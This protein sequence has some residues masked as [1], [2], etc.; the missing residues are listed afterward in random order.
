MRKINAGY[1]SGLRGKLRA[2]SDCTASARSI[3]LCGPTTPPAHP[4]GV[5]ERPKWRDHGLDSLG[6]LKQSRLISRNNSRA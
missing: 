3:E 5:A 4:I 1:R 6:D 2:S